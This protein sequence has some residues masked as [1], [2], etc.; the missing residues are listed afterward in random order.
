MQASLP[1]GNFAEGLFPGVSGAETADMRGLFGN[2]PAQT[3]GEKPVHKLYARLQKLNLARLFVSG[4][5]RP[6]EG[7]S[8]ES[9]YSSK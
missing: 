1:K 8:V 2:G 4:H 6:E 7:I 5:L 9:K 3:E